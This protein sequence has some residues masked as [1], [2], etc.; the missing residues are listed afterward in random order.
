MAGNLFAEGLSLGAAKTKIYEF[1]EYEKELG[2]LLLAEETDTVQRTTTL[3]L[4][5]Y[6]D[7]EELDEEIVEDLQAID[8]TARLREELSKENW[9]IGEVRMYL[10]A[11]RVSK[12]TNFS[13]F[14]RQNM[15]LLLPVIKDVILLL[16]E[17]QKDGDKT[18][19]DFT[20]ELIEIINEPVAQNIDVIRAWLLEMF[21]RNIVPFDAKHLRKLNSLR[22]TLDIRHLNIMKGQIK[23]VSYFRRNKK[24]LDQFNDWEKPSFIFAAKCLPED[25]YKV[26]IGNIKNRLDFPLARLFCDWCL[27]KAKL[28]YQ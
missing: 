8:L 5:L 26:W 14:A 4:L 2:A 19:D 9:N 15:R 23:D 21:T 7:E 6:D 24:N 1:E 25:E 18:F 17:L 28:E 11:L 3:F 27:Q 13:L 12:N 22:E 16:H 20:D 10:R